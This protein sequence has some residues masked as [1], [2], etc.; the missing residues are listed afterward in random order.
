[1]ATENYPAIHKRNLTVGLYFDWRCER[2]LDGIFTF[3]REVQWHLICDGAF[4]SHWTKPVSPLDGILCS[5]APDRNLAEIILSQRIP[6]VQ[7]FEEDGGLGKSE[8]MIHPDNTSIGTLAAN[9]FHSKGYRQVVVLSLSNRMA[10]SCRA[11]A[12]QEQSTKLG[13]HC[14]TIEF[15]KSCPNETSAKRLIH[16]LEKTGLPVGVFATS[17]I[18]AVQAMYVLLNKGYL[19]PE[20]VAIIGADNNLLVCE[21]APVPL[22]SIRLNS[23]SIGYKASSMLSN[24]MAGRKV[25]PTKMVVPP[26]GIVERQSTN[27][28]AVKSSNVLK[29]LGFISANFHRDIPLEEIADHCGIKQNLLSIL[30]RKHLRRSV[31]DEIKRQRIEAAKALLLQP[32]SRVHDVSQACGFGS[33]NYFHRVFLKTLGV[34]PLTYRKNA[35][36]LNLTNR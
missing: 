6:C 25:R 24:R 16:T 7:I 23:F 33:P 17:D 5:F 32:Q 28:A 22:T 29:A 3:A 21:R 2:V 19:V 13:I 4:D 36:V 14:N 1:M 11:Q 15:S 31:V 30:F 20:Q 35:S 18:L 8:I 9:Y 26:A 12:F 27:T 34:S 10:F